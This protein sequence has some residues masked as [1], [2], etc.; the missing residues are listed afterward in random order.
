MR[1]RCSSD[2][3]RTF[4][5][6]AARTV[7]DKSRYVGKFPCRSTPYTGGVFGWFKAELMDVR[8]TGIGCLGTG[9]DGC[10]GIGTDGCIDCIGTGCIGIGIG[11][12][13]TGM[14]C[15]G[16]GP[17]GCIGMG[18]MGTDGCEKSTGVVVG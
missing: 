5:L 15:I 9:T 11:C 16:T 10:I 12:I 18:C 2:M 3:G 17:E 6:G 13:G 4:G 8:Y 7:R 14:D 1:A